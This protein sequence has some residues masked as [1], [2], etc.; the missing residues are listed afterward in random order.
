M[1]ENKRVSQS[2]CRTVCN[3]W[4]EKGEIAKIVLYQTGKINR[5]LQ[6]LLLLG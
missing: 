3:Q 1:T 6:S 2:K 4:V 5:Y